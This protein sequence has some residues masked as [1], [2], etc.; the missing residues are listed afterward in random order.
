[1]HDVGNNF[2]YCLPGIVH[3]QG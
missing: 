3:C 2:P 1:M